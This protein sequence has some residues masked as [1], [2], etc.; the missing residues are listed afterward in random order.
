M[1]YFSTIERLKIAEIAITIFF[2][3]LMILTIY[4]RRPLRYVASIP[5]GIIALYSILLTS[6]PSYTTGPNKQDFFQTQKNKIVIFSKIYAPEEY[7]QIKTND[8][9]QKIP[10][11]T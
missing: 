9:I 5:L 3:C 7:I 4:I 6:I 1:E 8:T 11:I 10:I 2:C